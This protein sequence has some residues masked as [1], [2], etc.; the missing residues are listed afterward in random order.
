MRY[1]VFRRLTAVGL[2]TAGL[3]AFAAG[4]ASAHVEVTSPDATPGGFGL[5]VFQVP[6]ESDTASTVKVTVTLPADYPFGTVLSKTQPGWQVT[7]TERK[8]DKPVKTDDGFLLSKA[9]ATVTWTADPSAAIAPGQFDQFT[10]SVGPF[11]KGV[12][13]VQF[14]AV[15]TYSDGT[16]VNWDEPTPASGKEPEHP[17]PTLT[18]ASVATGHDSLARGLGI[19]GLAVGALALVGLAVRRPAT[20]VRP[21]G[22]E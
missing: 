10:L 22:E 16:V 14:P 19:G 4:P 11:P 5:L 6:C 7:T 2:L 18:F 15:Q 8:L 3:V 17:T 12:D 1:A 13:A 20:K 9:V 21:G